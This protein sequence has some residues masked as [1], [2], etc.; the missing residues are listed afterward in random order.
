MHQKNAS[1][2][3]GLD[4]CRGNGAAKSTIMTP[5]RA[6]LAPEVSIAGPPHREHVFETK[7]IVVPSVSNAPWTPPPRMA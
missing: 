4:V 5:H 6:V 1:G 7:T 3:L 2:A